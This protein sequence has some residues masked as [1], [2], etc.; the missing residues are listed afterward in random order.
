MGLGG[1]G[2]YFLALVHLV[3]VENRGALIVPL[4]TKAMLADITLRITLHDAENKAVQEQLER[5]TPLGTVFDGLQE[6][7]TEYMLSNPFATSFVSSNR[8]MKGSFGGMLP[9]LTW[10]C[11][12]WVI[13]FIIGLAVALWREGVSDM[14]SGKYLAFTWDLERR[15]LYRFMIYGM[16][17]ASMLLFVGFNAFMFMSDGVGGV[18]SAMYAGVV[19]FGAWVYGLMSLLSGHEPAFHWKNSDEFNELTFTRTFRQLFISNDQYALLLQA[20]LI[21]HV[22]GRNADE[23]GD[24]EVPPIGDFVSDEDAAYDIMMTPYK[25]DGKSTLKSDTS[26]LRGMF[27]CNSSW[28]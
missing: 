15:S 3:I 17:G 18:V 10:A 6:A 22:R 24:E 23:S 7:T 13:L 16:L 27:N 11:I 12:A 26:L 19:N 25:T 1:I 21:H 4:T 2:G 20:A 28:A 9:K 14:G 8:L 5:Q